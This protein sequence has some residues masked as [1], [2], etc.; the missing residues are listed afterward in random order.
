MPAIRSVVPYVIKPSPYT[1][2][3]RCGGRLINQVLPPC[4]VNVVTGDP[5]WVPTDPA[6]DVD[7]VVVY[8]FEIATGK[9]IKCRVLHKLLS[10]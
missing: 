6:Q 4:V 1:P 2:L 9:K 3:L 5:T 7:K 8:G 10:V